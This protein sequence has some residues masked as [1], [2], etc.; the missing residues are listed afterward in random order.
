MYMLKCV[1]DGSDNPN[2]TSDTSPNFGQVISS[3]FNQVNPAKRLTTSYK[4]YC[5]LFQTTIG[6]YEKI[7]NGN[8]IVV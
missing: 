5:A 4:Q 1:I 8:S 2:L 7:L 3:C 6:I